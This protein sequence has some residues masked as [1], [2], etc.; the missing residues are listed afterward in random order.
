MSSKEYEKPG[1][2]LFEPWH[3]VKY[4]VEK[5]SKSLSEKLNNPE[6][7]ENGLKL[8][9]PYANKLIPTNFDILPENGDLSRRPI[10]LNQWPETD[11][12]YKKDD[13]YKLPKAFIAA[14]IYSNDCGF[15]KTPR[16][17]VFVSMWVSV[18]KNYLAEL[19]YMG[20]CAELEFYIDQAVD[21]VEIRW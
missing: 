2:K 12:W 13:E 20:I 7:V 19:T 21:N 14:K 8:D 9:L 5:F 4:E 3:K 17:S 10:L 11:I 6:I 15:G 1:L 18:L 16:G